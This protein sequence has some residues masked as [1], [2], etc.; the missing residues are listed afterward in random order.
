MKHLH[1]TKKIAAISSAACLA[2]SVF[3]N[4]VATLSTQ[5]AA[6]ETQIQ[7]YSDKIQWIYRV[8]NNKLYKRLYNYAT[9]NWVG[10]WIYVRDM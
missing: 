6:G 5:A 1:I 2:L 10:E 3:L 9:G 7:P 8:E 4:P